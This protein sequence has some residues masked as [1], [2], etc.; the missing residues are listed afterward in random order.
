MIVGV[1]VLVGEPP[2]RAVK[3]DMVPRDRVALALDAGQR[4]RDR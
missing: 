4:D 1:S 3:V 2:L